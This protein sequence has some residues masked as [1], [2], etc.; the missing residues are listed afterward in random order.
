MAKIATEHG[1]TVGDIW[2]HP[3]NAAHRAKRGSPD[4]LYPG[5]V[6]VIPQL[7]PPQLVPPHL[8][9]P[10]PGAICGTIAAVAEA[11]RAAFR[12]RWVLRPSLLGRGE[13]FR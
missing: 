4:I 6:L 12:G 9:P 1:V 2:K 8:P 11:D 5:D 3:G 13:T 10:P 7:A